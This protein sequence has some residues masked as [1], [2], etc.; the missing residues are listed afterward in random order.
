MAVVCKKKQILQFWTNMKTPLTYV[1][2]Q[3]YFQ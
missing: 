3:N 2:E 1:N